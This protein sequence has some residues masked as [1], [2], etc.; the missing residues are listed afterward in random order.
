MPRPTLRTVLLSTLLGALLLPVAPPAPAAGDEA[1]ASVRVRGLLAGLRSED[2][3]VAHAA[4]RAL[5]HVPLQQRVAPWCEVLHGAAPPWRTRAAGELA[6]LGDPRALPAL[7][8]AA[9]GDRD[10]SVRGAAV[11][12]LTTL[13]APGTTLAVARALGRPLATERVHAIEALGALGDPAGAAF[14]LHRWHATSGDFPRVHIT[15]VNQVSYIQDFDVEVASTS[16]IA[17]PIVG[18]LQDGFVLDVKVLGAEH[19]FSTL[20]RVAARRMLTAIA[21]RDH[22]PRLE[23]WRRWWR[24]QGSTQGR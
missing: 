3:V 8:E 23:A 2:P 14:V 5:R 12:A 13:R 17:D 11:A 20:E 6:R 15:Q 21:G 9:V 19:G 16:F 7:V 10:A 24:D 22:G 4:R 18:T 1:D